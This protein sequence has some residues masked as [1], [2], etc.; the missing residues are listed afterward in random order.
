MKTDLIGKS[1]PY[2]VL[3][4]AD[5][6]DKTPV[7]KNTQNPQWDHNSQFS[8]DP[9]D[10][11]HLRYFLDMLIRLFFDNIGWIKSVLWENS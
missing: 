9:E 1:D 4:Y 8:L 6:Q 7:I 11:K 2:A 3:K 5:E 10:T